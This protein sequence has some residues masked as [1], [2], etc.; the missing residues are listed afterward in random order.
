VTGSGQSLDV[1][2]V[3]YHSRPL[4]G[5]AMAVAHELG[6]DA[7][8]LILVD[9]SPGDGSAEIVRSAEPG[10]V[11]ITNRENRGY[12]AAVNQALAVAS[13]D[14]VLLLNP[15]VQRISGSYRDVVDAFGD[16]R[17]AAV[18]PRLVDT[19]GAVQPS[20]FRAPRPFDLLSEDLALAERLPSWRRPRRYR[21]LDWSYD[22]VRRVDAATGACLFLRR[23]ALTD[24]G[25]FDE[26]FFVYYE[27]TDW[28]VR[29]KRRGWKT[30]FLP[31]LEAVH[32]S[33]GSSPGVAA[34]PSLLLLES[35][36][37]YARKHFGLPWSLSLRAALLGIDTARLVRHSLARR[38]P[39]TRA[40]RTRI[41]VHLKARAPRPS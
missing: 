4:I 30:V 20:C 23:A 40:A 1:V 13:A 2:I 11:V 25:P 41:R 37:Q 38:A 28:M 34:G 3:N 32:V 12:A 26:R 15:D 7:I 22:D 19:D 35:Q 5:R 27:E 9:N 21:M 36:H 6:G 29:A 18:V 31:S 33:A 17:V 24:V 14:T 10:A 16:P 39:Q 8:R